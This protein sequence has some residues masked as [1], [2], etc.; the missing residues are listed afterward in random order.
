[1]N[2][3]EKTGPPQSDDRSGAGNAASPPGAD[4]HTPSIQRADR[5]LT[6]AALNPD[7]GLISGAPPAPSKVVMLLAVL[8]LAVAAGWR[9]TLA[10]AMPCLARDGVLYIDFAKAMTSTGLDALRDPRFEQHPLY[11]AAIAGAHWFWLACGGDD[12]PLGWQRVGQGVAILAG[13]LVVGLCGLL[14]RRMAQRLG[15][16]AEAGA[17]GLIAMLVAALLPLNT[18]LSA[19]VMSDE[20]HAALF[21]ACIGLGLG[22]QRPAVAVVAGLAGGLAFLARPEGA[23]AVLLIGSALWFARPGPRQV[24]RRV[25][26]FV[27]MLAGFLLMAAPYWAALG[28]LS[29]KV[30]KQT[31]EEFQSAAA[32][33]LMNRPSGP[34]APAHAALLRR[35]LSWPMAALRAVTELFRAGRVV[36]PLLALVS[37]VR[38]GRRWRDWPLFVAFEGIAIMLALATVLLERYG[39]LTPR[40]L[41]IA[42]LLLIPL[43]AIGVCVLKCKAGWRWSDW[44]LVALVVGVCGPLAVY[45]LRVPN[46]ADRDVAAAGWWLARQPTTVPGQLL[47][48]GASERRIAFYGGVRWQGWPENAKGDARWQALREHLFDYRPAYLAI[49]VGSGDELAGNAALVEALRADAALSQRLKLVHAEPGDP[50]GQVLVF[51]LDWGDGGARA[52]NSPG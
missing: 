13:L 50:D 17:V 23:V 31:I 15:Y 18:W 27:C 5:S 8:I 20:L 36:V 9:V 40:H 22:V 10:V 14:G 49:T 44:R 25:V 3:D 4:A 28:E 32:D 21:L 37:I 11:S 35:E 16:A 39:Y 7:A 2:S 24:W 26:L 42:V 6:V 29:P 1:M 45:S 47:L 33:Q 43:A 51:R 19:D 38:L 46:G 41:L 34:V 30:R 12:W 52:Y 48:G